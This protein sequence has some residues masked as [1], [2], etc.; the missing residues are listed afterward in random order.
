MTQLIGKIDEESRRRPRG[1]YRGRQGVRLI[2]QEIADEIEARWRGARVSVDLDTVEE[3]DAFL[4][5]TPP[6]PALRDRVALTALELVNSMA[7][8]VGFWVVPRVLNDVQSADESHRL[9]IR[10]AANPEAMSP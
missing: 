8:R 7:A 4:W 2:S 3:E 6:N 1:T 5:I 10:N 9:R